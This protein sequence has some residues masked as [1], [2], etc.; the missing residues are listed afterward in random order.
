MCVMR[1]RSVEWDV[2]NPP[3]AFS[4][5]VDTKYSQTYACCDSTVGVYACVCVC[6]CVCVYAC[7]CK[8]LK[9]FDINLR[10]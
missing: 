8:A 7:V 6:V 4:F 5:S 9:A 1:H 10:N 2:Y 3:G